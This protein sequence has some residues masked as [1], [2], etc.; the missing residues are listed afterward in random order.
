MDFDGVIEEY[1]ENVDKKEIEDLAKKLI[2]KGKPFFDLEGMLGSK[3]MAQL[4]AVAQK[5][6]MHGF[7]SLRKPE[8]IERIKQ[9]ILEYIEDFEEDLLDLEKFE[10]EMF[11]EAAKKKVHME[12]FLPFPVCMN[13]VLLG[14]AGM[15]NAEE[16]FSLVI[17]REIKSRF[18]RLEK[19]GFVPFK[20]YSDIC[21][22]LAMA[23]SNLYGFISI[24]DY[25]GLLKHFVDMEHDKD[26]ITGILDTTQFRDDTDYYETDDDN[27]YHS[28]FLY[29]EEERIEEIIDA[30]Y[31]KP[32][33]LPKEEEFLK[34]VS[35]DYLGEKSGLEP[36]SDFLSKYTDFFN[37]KFVMGVLRYLFAMEEEYGQMIDVIE[38]CEISLRPSAKNKFIKLVEEARDNV[39]LWSNKGFSNRELE[40]LH[41]PNI[42]LFP[43]Q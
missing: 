33:Y 37:L 42:S 22:I 4:K 8:L 3:N 17:P 16:G 18:A 13:L 30:A 38:V 5:R 34:Y 23:C 29:M 41:K 21:H 20:I 12:K 28:E 9:D 24:D 1:W 25:I 26:V 7:R 6:E 43:P 27:I 35:F 36:I 2:C 11:I 15:Y 39:R 40:I 19:E 31:D 10:F 14:Y 32:R